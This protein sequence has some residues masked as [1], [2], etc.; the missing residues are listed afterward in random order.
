[1]GR[2]IYSPY[3]LLIILVIAIFSS[4]VYINI[5][6]YLLPPL[7]QSIQLVIAPI[8]LMGVT[9]PMLYLFLLRPMALS[10]NE[11]RQMEESLRLSVEKFRTLF[12]QSRDPIYIVTRDGEFID[13]NSAM[14]DLLYYSRDEMMKLN[15]RELY[16]HPGDRDRFQQEIE[17]K[18]TIKEFEVKIRRKD[19][20]EVDCLITST[21]WYNQEGKKVGYQG[22]IRDITERKRVETELKFLSTHDTLTGLYNRAYFEEEMARLERGRRFPV[23]IVMADI[24]GLKKV[25]DSHGHVIGDELI[26]GAAD[27]LRSSFRA[28]DIVARIGGDEFAV[29]L[30]NTGHLDTE[31]IL[32]RVKNN[33]MIHNSGPARLPMSI[34]LGASTCEK[35][36]I[37]ARVLK[38]ADENM[39]QNKPTEKGHG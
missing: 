30:P 1:M 7:P 3:R 29:L 23:S 39:Y 19:G 34:S 9:F 8:L 5:L 24:D 20:A 4:E 37:M 27:L 26:K 18:G 16:V 28:E 35:G 15:A 13:F 21:I 6:I 14:L 2:D 22:V 38:K 10:F 17:K 33:I 36:D 25:N 31:R 12:E 11:H 32:A